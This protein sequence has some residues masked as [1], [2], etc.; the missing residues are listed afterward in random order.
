MFHSLQQGNKVGDT[1]E[2]NREVS[3]ACVWLL[4]EKGRWHLNKIQIPWTKVHL[5][6]LCTVE[7]SSARPQISFETKTK[8]CLGSIFMLRPRPIPGLDQSSLGFQ[9]QYRE[10]WTTAS[11][12][13]LWPTIF[14]MNPGLS[15]SSH[16]WAKKTVRPLE[17]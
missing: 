11:V 7:L 10:S 8:T 15:Y 17:S 13:L 4:L 16:V 6:K 12:T 3:C 1:R 2:I 9:F 14:A 5:Y